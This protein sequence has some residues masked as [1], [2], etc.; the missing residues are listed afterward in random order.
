MEF[1]EGNRIKIDPPARAIYEKSSCFENL[2][3]YPNS[4]K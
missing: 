4:F 2:I 1:I 3:P